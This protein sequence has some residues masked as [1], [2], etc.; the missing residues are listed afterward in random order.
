MNPV[1]NSGEDPFKRGAGLGIDLGKRGI[2]QVYTGEGKGKTTAALGLI[3]RALGQDLRVLLVRFLKPAEG[4]GEVVFFKNMPRVEI[5]SSGIGYLEGLK[6]WERLCQSAIDTF[7]AVQKKI[8]TGC[9]DLVVLDEINNVMDFGMIPVEEVIR[10]IDL[11]PWHTEL[12]LTGRNAPGQII[13]KAEL[14][15]CMK[16]VKHVFEEGMSA[17]RGIEY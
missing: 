1:V 9:F 12:V 5:L 13:E 14:V 7:R 8:L 3:T 15:T 10:L 2:V 11:K 16:M 6:D 4:S 17:R